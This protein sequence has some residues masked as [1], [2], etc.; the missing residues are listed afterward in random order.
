MR[1]SPI[2]ANL[3]LGLLLCHQGYTLD[4]RVD[5]GDLSLLPPA[6]PAVCG[7]STDRGSS[8]DDAAR[9]VEFG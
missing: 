5:V 2:G 1:Q 9:E 3:Y 6:S 7:D 8:A 4:H